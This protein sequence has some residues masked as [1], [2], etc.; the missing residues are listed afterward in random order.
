MYIVRLTNFRLKTHQKAKYINWFKSNN[1]N[2]IPVE[3]IV[4]KMFSQTHKIV[5][6]IYIHVK[7]WS[8]AWSGAKLCIVF[9]LA[10]LSLF[11]WFVWFEHFLLSEM[12]ASWNENEDGKICIYIR[13]EVDL[14]GFQF[15]YKWARIQVLIHLLIFFKIKNDEFVSFFR[16]YWEG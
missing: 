16:G 12:T 11:V 13:S 3:N 9:V 15:W 8:F 7:L 6:F 10:I 5:K 1:E 14:F 2:N 4:N